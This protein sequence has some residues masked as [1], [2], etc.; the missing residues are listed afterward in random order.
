MA[1]SFYYG[2]GSPYAWR[3]WLALEHKQLPYTLTTLS[4]SAGDTRKPEFLELN[5][6]HRVPVIID[7]D[8]VLYESVA[9]VKYLED[10]Y[11]QSGGALFPIEAR[12]RAIV[13]RIIQEV[14][15]YYGIANEQIV[16][17]ILFK[18]KAEWDL[19][20]I[21]RAREILVEEIV[22]FEVLLKNNYLAG[23]LSAADFTLYPLIALTLRMETKAP[24]LAIRREIG[25]KLGAWM[26]RVES[27]PFF[28]KTYP[29][30]W[31]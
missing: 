1:I 4:F 5:P 18:V 27:L 24:D 19:D 3:V 25:P 17:E 6:R 31:R 2:S 16:G 26:H 30:H 20:G 12:R 7:G 29:P 8:F 13:R 28:D 9:I 22:R 21:S 23:E 15:Q 11:P 10:G 14:D